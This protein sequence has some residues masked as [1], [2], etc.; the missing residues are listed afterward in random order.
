MTL[1]LPLLVALLTLFQTP[2][3]GA[4]QLAGVTV[5]GIKRFTSADVVKIS[6]LAIGQPASVQALDGAASKLAGTGLFKTVNYRYTTSAGKLNA[7]LDVEEEPWTLPTVFDNFIWFTD[8]ELVAA[9][10]E[11]VP[12]FDGTMPANDAAVDYVAQALQRFM[13]AR[14]ITG[15]VS[16]EGR[17]SIKTGTRQELFMVSGTTSSLKMCALKIPGASAVPEADLVKVAASVIGTNYSRAFVD[18]LASGTLRQEYRRRGY[19]AADLAFQAAALNQGC[20][21]VTVSVSAKE[22]AVYA[23]D[24]VEW[25]GTAGIPPADLNKAFGI[26]TGDASGLMAVDAGVRAVHAAYDK[27]GY[28]MQE[29]AYTPVLDDAAHRMTLQMKVTEG[30]QF[31]MGT[32]TFP[33]LPPAD[34]ERLIKKWKIAPGE[35]YDGSYLASYTVGEVNPVKGRG[36][37][38]RDLRAEISVDR[39]KSLVHVRFVVP[40]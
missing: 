33:D 19:W 27:I 28:I 2:A 38:P 20:D 9:V 37:V 40:R 31:R 12:T 16:G 32:L 23:F 22:G 11:S 21:G 13:D 17:V 34:A 3:P 25:S 10:R 7:I 35:I 15:R 1:V 39:T 6:G 29:A 4:M 8:Q 18:G 26:K 36:S 30:Q 14:K 24:H 5:N